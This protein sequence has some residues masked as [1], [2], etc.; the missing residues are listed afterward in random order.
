MVES[1]RPIDATGWE[2]SES[3]DETCDGGDGDGCSDG[4]GGCCCRFDTLTEHHWNK[5]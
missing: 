5:S 2:A 1:L 4:D 3:W